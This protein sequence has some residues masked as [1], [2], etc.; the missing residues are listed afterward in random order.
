M[1]HDSY[2]RE[3][4]GSWLNRRMYGDDKDHEGVWW[5]NG[6]GQFLW[7]CHGWLQAVGPKKMCVVWSPCKLLHHDSDFWSAITYIYI[8]RHKHMCGL[9][10]YCTTLL[11]MYLYCIQTMREHLYKIVLSLPYVICWHP[12]TSL[13]IFGTVLLLGHHG[14]HPML[15]LIATSLLLLETCSGFKTSVGIW[16]DFFS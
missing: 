15:Q 4:E 16:Y 14:W 12:L 8:Y 7:H 2:V 6:Y 9:W 10:F 5:V 3:P 13:D 11:N 1:G